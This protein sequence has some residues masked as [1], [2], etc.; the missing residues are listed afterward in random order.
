MKKIVEFAQ[1]PFIERRE[2]WQQLAPEF[3]V[4]FIDFQEGRD[5]LFA[6]FQ[7]IFAEADVALVSADYSKIFFEYFPQISR[8]LLEVGRIDMIEKTQITS[9][10]CLAREALHELIVEKAP[11][12]DTH[13][14]AYVTGADASMRVALSVLVQLGYRHINIVHDEVEMIEGIISELKRFYFGVQLYSLKN[15][16]LTLQPNNG[17]ILINTVQLDNQPDLLQDLSYLNFIYGSGLIVETNTFPLGH[18]LIDEAKNV[19]LTVLSGAEVGGQVDW[20]FLRKLFGQVPWPAGEYRQKWI[21]FLKNTAK[22]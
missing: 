4:E 12:L 2:F 1:Q 3:A 22:V 5:Q 14:K 20:M 11:N 8:R 17:S 13:A 19:G 16:D 7:K 6:D 21:Q 15:M 18:S 10:L 9:P